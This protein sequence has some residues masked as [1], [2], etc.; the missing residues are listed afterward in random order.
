LNFKGLKTFG[1]RALKLVKIG[2][3][4]QPEAILSGECRKTEGG[5][6]IMIFIG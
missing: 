5:W 1:F 6:L 2:G 3:I 4:K